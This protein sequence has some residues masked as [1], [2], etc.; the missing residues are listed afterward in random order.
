MSITLLYFT[1]KGSSSRPICVAPNGTQDPACG[2]STSPCSLFGGLDLTVSEFPIAFELLLRAGSYE[3]SS[4]YEA[5]GSS[6]HVTL[7]PDEEGVCGPPVPVTGA[8]APVVFAS[9]DGYRG[10]FF[11]FESRKRA[12]SQSDDDF[13]AR[14]FQIVSMSMTL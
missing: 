2:N 9:A 11:S 8:D 4:E 6:L 12:F 7:R 10:R 3:F 5:L 13:K 1:S 14:V